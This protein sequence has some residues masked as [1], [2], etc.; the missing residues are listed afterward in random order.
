MIYLDLEDL[1]HVAQRVLDEVLVRDMGLLEATASRSRATAFGEDAYP[2]LPTKAAALLHSVVTS[3]PLVDENKRLGLAATIA[4]LGVNGRRLELT[5]DEAYELVMEVAAGELDDVAV[6]ASRL[7]SRR[8]RL[9]RLARQSSGSVQPCSG[10][11]PTAPS[12]CG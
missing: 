4:F 12:T 6:I 5:N 3:H 2:D 1:L 7:G 11:L 10:Q 8:R 9:N